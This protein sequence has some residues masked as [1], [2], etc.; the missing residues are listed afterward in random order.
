MEK[1]GF[2]RF[3]VAGLFF[4]F[5]PVFLVFFYVVYVRLFFLKP[6]HIVTPNVSFTLQI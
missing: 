1:R 3:P 2:C 5:L 6:K 4:F